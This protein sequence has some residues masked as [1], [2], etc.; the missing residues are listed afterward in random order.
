M[1]FC[2][3][4]FEV[5]SKRTAPSELFRRPPFAFRLRPAFT[6]V[7]LLVVMT[8]MAV[9][10]S[11]VLMALSSSTESA[12]SSKTQSTINKLNSIIMAK[13]ESYRT[14]RVPVDVKL[15]AI[16]KGY[17]A[18]PTGWAHA[19][20]DVIREL[21]RMEM[22]DGFTDIDDGPI[23]KWNSN[24]NTMARPAASQ[25]YLAML[26]AAR[27]QYGASAVSNTT[28]QQAMCLYMI[29]T[30]GSDDPDVLEQFQT[31]EIAADTATGL[32]YFVDGW[33]RPIY[34]LRWA[35]AYISA[36]QPDPT[37]VT[38]HD[39]FDPLNVEPSQYQPTYPLYPLIYSAGQDGVFD[40]I[41]GPASPPFQYSKVN[42]DPFYNGT[43]QGSLYNASPT[44]QFKQKVG[45]G[46]ADGDG[47][48]QSIDNIT[49]HDIGEN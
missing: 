45:A 17:P 26:T 4:Q 36:L 8:I 41:A 18:S 15:V 44:Y 43:N 9:L 6:L 2:E 47:N 14:R 27:N 48:D 7:E 19:R 13:Y 31:N 32:K 10:S 46:D 33:G 16:Q 37:T 22:P 21:M 40:I 11:M 3:I 28:L 34:Y 38:Q 42:N 1:N 12:K 20:L 35:P 23:T 30:H 25:T 39:P 5:K 49:N 24:A 29:V